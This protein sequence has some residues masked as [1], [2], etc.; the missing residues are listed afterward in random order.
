MHA[1]KLATITVDTT[2]IGEYRDEWQPVALSYVV[3]VLVMRWCQLDSTSPVLGVHMLVGHHHQLAVGD[4]GVHELAADQV[5]VPGVIGVHGDT[6]VTEHGLYPGGRDGDMLLRIRAL[7]LVL[8]DPQGPHLNG[9]V[10][11]RYLDPN[12]G[13]DLESV[14]LDVGKRRREVGAP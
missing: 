10:V 12:W 3:V 11:S 8:E 5:T 9:G 7:H 4:E 14:H 2:V 6:D 1:F 13:C